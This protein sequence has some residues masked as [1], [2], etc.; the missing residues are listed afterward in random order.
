MGFPIPFTRMLL[1]EH[2]YKKISG[3]VLLL[4]RPSISCTPEQVVKIVQEELGHVIGNE[5]ILT[6]TLT[7]TGRD[8]GGIFI[9]D[10]GFFKL[11]TDAVVSVMDVTDYEGADIVH[12]LTETIPTALEDRFDFIIDGGCLDNIF[13][14]AAAIRNMT[15]ML[16]PGG[17]VMS[18]NV[19]SNSFVPYLILSADWLFDYYHV[20][21]FDDC[22]VNLLLWDNP[23][24]PCDLFSYEPIYR[25][26]RGLLR[27]AV[28]PFAPKRSAFV[29]ALAEKALSGSTWDRSPIQK[30]Y[31]P[32][33]LCAENTA[34]TEMFLASE[35]PKRPSCP[36][37]PGTSLPAENMQYRGI[38]LGAD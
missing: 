11:F 15:R 13:D 10:V 5:H 20:N 2:K 8:A 18:L 34:I 12:D 4:G 1:Q 6:D 30:P 32:E 38:L 36:L 26:P 22:R 24:G 37:P 29:V 16:K 23:D 7:L 35:R 28:F 21:R 31:R 14:P 19:A 33:Y 17:R 9:S 27:H 25:N 3:N